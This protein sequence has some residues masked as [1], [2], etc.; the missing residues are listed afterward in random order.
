MI[1][2][3]LKQ[4]R[5]IWKEMDPMMRLVWRT[6]ALIWKGTMPIMRMVP[7]RMTESIWMRMVPETQIS[8]M[9]KKRPL[10]QGRNKP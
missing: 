10:A 1:A 2:S 9:E 8:Q 6:E 3:S 7:I 4:E 5:N